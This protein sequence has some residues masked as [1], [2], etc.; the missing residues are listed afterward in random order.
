MV[1]GLD[2]PGD[3]SHVLTSVPPAGWNGLEARQLSVVLLSL[4]CVVCLLSELP[5]GII[6]EGKLLRAPA[7]GVSEGGWVGG[8]RRADSCCGW[9]S[10]RFEAREMV[11]V[12]ES[13]G[14][15]NGLQR[16]MLPI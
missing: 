3:G 7:S 4:D 8:A 2:E 1:T 10:H 5:K 9:H 12:N 14:Y 6:A 11:E 13:W 15:H 16:R